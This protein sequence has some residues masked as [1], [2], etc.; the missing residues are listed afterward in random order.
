MM[1][2][3]GYGLGGGSGTT[4]VVVSGIVNADISH[5]ISANVEAQPL[6]ANAQDVLSADIEAETL[7]AD[8][9]SLPGDIKW[10]TG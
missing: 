10:L 4:T 1:A 5:T 9:K 2:T 3:Y 7:T 6:D 8:T